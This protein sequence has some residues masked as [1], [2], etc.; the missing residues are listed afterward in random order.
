MKKYYLILLLFNAT[1]ALGQTPQRVAYTYDAL[2]RLTEVTYPNGSKITYSYDV[3]GNRQ[4]Q[5]ISN[6]CTPPPAPSVNSPTITSGQTATL[7]A[8]GCS[9]T[10]TW[11]AAATGGSAVFTGN[12]FTTPALTAN[13]SY[14]AECSVNGCVSVSR[15]SGMVTITQPANPCPP[16][17]THSGNISTGVYTAAQSISSTGNVPTNTSY[18]AGRSITLLPGFSAGSNENFTAR[19]Q[20]CATI[21]TNGLI[22]YYPFSGNANDLSGNANNGIVNGA[23]LTTDRFGVAN[24]AY[25]FNDGN[26][27]QVANSAS[28]NLLNAFT[29]STWVNLQSTMGRDGYGNLSSYGYHPIFTKNCDRGQLQMAI[30]PATNGTFKLNTYA[31]AGGN[32]PIIPLALNQWKHLTVVY[33]GT[34]IKHFVDGTMITTKLVSMDLAATNASDLFI[35]KM[36]CFNY[37]LNGLIDDFR[38]YNRALTDAEVQSIYAVER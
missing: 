24:K 7:T 35:G 9:G 17:I 13:T 31:G 8:T 22:A 16:T 28:L 18:F 25:R 5:V 11:F 1:V 21:P 26:F 38:I 23:T 19:I 27:I 14:F 37:F 20:G 3:L 29:I 33:D 12:P 34:A 15:G 6:I 36:G 2:N 32:N 30:E 4:T 10:V